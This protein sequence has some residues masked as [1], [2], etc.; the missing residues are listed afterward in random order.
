MAIFDGFS[1]QDVQRITSAGRFVRLP[2]HWSVMWERTPSDKAYIILS[3][4]VSIR[5][6]GQEIGTLGTGDVMGEAGIV[7][8]RLRSASVVTTTPVELL[9]FTAEEVR[10]LA[11]EVPAF[12][13]ALG[14]AAAAHLG[15]GT[16]GSA[17]G[18]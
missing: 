13:D 10:R 15:G 2:A 8:H 6:N 7:N 14:R 5:R 12:G 11:V 18:G 4:E 9:H 16:T 3:G 1:D 17:S